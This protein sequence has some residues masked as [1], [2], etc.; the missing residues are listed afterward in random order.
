[1]VKSTC[2]SIIRTGGWILALTN[3]FYNS[4][5]KESNVPFRPLW[6][7]AQTHIIKMK[8][9]RN[10]AGGVVQLVEYLPNKKP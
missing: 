2:H 9:L 7:L 3:A 8:I 10:R 1:M 4:N 5:S 6:A